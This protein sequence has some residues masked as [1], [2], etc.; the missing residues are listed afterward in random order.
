EKLLELQRGELQRI[1][2]AAGHT[3]YYRKLFADRG[4]EIS[5]LRGPEDLAQIPIL[6][7]ETVRQNPERFVDERLDLRRLYTSLTSGS[8]GTPIRVFQT[9]TFEPI[10]EAFLA[11]Q[12]RWAGFSPTD[13][14]VKIRG[15]LLLPASMDSARPW[16]RNL[17]SR[18]LRMS[19]YHLSPT[20][21]QAYVDRIRGFRPRAII[22]YPSSVSSLAALARDAV[23]RLQVPLVFTSS[24][25]L[26]PAQRGL[27]ED[28]FGARVF[29]H[30][31]MTEGAVA[32]QECERGTYHVIPEYGVT[33]L[34]PVG[35][36]ASGE[37][38]EVVSTGLINRAMPLL[39]YRTGDIV[40]IKQDDGRCACGRHFTAVREILGRQED[41][42][43]AAS[44]A[45]VGRLNFV[46]GGL[47]G[48]VEAQ[49]EQEANHDIVVRVVRGA[50][51]GRKTEEEIRRN[52]LDR[53]GNLK[54]SI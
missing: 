12:W 48:V 16:R 18:E 26:S 15:D 32:I 41:I 35:D 13:R 43:Q 27:I 46:F 31:G 2:E 20:T 44:G 24:E 8:S 17:A 36:D 3:P 7:K 40:R 23:P 53:V 34:L 25:T 33:E 10:E 22:A 45:W 4:I 38:R 21:V 29:D 14:R 6:D 9:Q 39:R 1:V 49:I 52:L 30:Y 50:G 51:Y 11:R 37:L 19:A 42:V 54:V 47:S 5:R 28:A